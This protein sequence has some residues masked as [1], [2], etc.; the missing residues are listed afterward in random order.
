MADHQEDAQW[1]HSPPERH[2]GETLEA[3]I[4]RRGARM[5]KVQALLAVYEEELEALGAGPEYDRILAAGRTLQDEASHLW[6]WP[7]EEEHIQYGQA[8]KVAVIDEL[9]A[10][11]AARDDARNAGRLDEARRL[12]MEV[13]RIE[14]RFHRVFHPDQA[15]VSAQHDLSGRHRVDHRAIRHELERARTEHAAATATDRPDRFQWKWAERQYREL[16]ERAC[17]EAAEAREELLAQGLI[18]PRAAADQAT[19]AR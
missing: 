18:R 4:I 12:E 13:Q 10:A 2:P 6:L 3:Y 1:R 11:E 17:R 5:R 19:A 9:R 15:A 7:E 16:W 14:E 8:G